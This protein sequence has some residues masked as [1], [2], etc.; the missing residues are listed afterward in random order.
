M[1]LT[2]LFTAV[3]SIDIK[4]RHLKPNTSTILVC[5]SGLLA[6]QRS[7]MIS[8]IFGLEKIKIR[9]KHVKTFLQPAISLK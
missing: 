6:D 5:T 2:A 3:I 1:H 8:M 9:D 7:W 4:I